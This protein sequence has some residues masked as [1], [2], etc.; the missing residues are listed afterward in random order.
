MFFRFR[1]W[2]LYVGFTTVSPDCL[3]VGSRASTVP[4]GWRIA[5][6]RGRADPLTEHGRTREV[7]VRNRWLLDSSKS[8]PKRA[9]G[10]KARVTA[11]LQTVLIDAN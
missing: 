4:P 2:G 10:V 6:P 7:G 9:F 8:Y 1:L 3:G 11:P 5:H